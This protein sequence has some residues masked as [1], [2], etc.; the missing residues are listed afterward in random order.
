M[1]LL[2]E[3]YDRYYRFLKFIVKYWNS[4]LF[5]SEDKYLGEERLGAE[6]GQE[7]DPPPAELVADLK[8]L[9]PTFVKLGQLLSTRPDILP[10]PYLNALAELQDQVDPIPFEEVQRLFQEETGKPISHSFSFFD[11]KP[12]ASASIGQVHV[13]RFFSGE[14]V[15][16]KIQRPGIDGRFVEDLDA[17]MTLSEKAEEYSET[18]RKFSVYEIIEEMKYILIQ[19]LDYEREARNL[20]V[21]KENMKEFKYLK[22]PKVYTSHSSPKILTMEYIRGQKVTDLSPSQLMDL[23]KKEIVDDLI[24]GYLKQI[25]VDGFAHAD[26][27]PGNVHVTE[28]R[29]LV[30]LDL[31]MVA[32]F[33]KHFQN[34]ILRFMIGLSDNDGDQ[35][36]NVLLEISEYE[37]DAVKENEFRKMVSRKIQDAK[38][39][40]AKDLR[41]GRDILEINQLAAK[42]GIRLPVELTILGKILLNMDQIIACL[43]PQHEMQKTVKS[44]IEHLMRKRTAKDLRSGSFLET[45]LESRD[46]A[47]NLPHRLNKISENLAANKFRVKL[48]AIDEN[49]FLYAFQKVA[50]RISISL[51]VAALILGAA[52]IMRIPTASTLWGYPTLAILL[53]LAATCIGLYLVYQIL[54]KDESEPKK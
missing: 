45:L 33:S 20:K 32:Q 34:I 18:A 25:I 54:F 38:H 27:H 13:A 22:I 29:Q 43:S 16:I 19:E 31:G 1:S 4:D 28:L 30:L 47:K 11:E 36:C 53:F 48:D 41:T 9:G 24:K 42:N 21:L 37:E 46:L 5:S 44:Y 50:N 7:L 2:P 14:E 51:I 6:R 17:L 26:P 3:K 10:A 35:V 52:L 39:S 15:A 12:L 40:K 49:R 8:D 23:P